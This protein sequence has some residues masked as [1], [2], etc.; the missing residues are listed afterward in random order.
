[1]VNTAEIH[2]R[3]RFTLILGYENSFKIP[4]G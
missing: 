4:K 1:M 2:A 3:E